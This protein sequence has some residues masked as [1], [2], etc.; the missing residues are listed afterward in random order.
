MKTNAIPDLVESVSFLPLLY[1]HVR[2][3]KKSW[4]LW[5]EVKSLGEMLLSVKATRIQ[6]FSFVKGSAGRRRAAGDI[7]VTTD[8]VRWGR[9]ELDPRIC[10]RVSKEI[11]TLALLSAVK[12]CDVGSITARNAAILVIVHLVW[13]LSSR[14]FRVL[15]ICGAPRRECAHTCVASCHPSSPCPDNRCKVVVRITC[16]CGR[17]SGEVPCDAGGSGGR[18][19]A[20]TEMILSRLPGPLQ[21]LPQGSERVPLGQ[22]KLSCDDECAKHEKRK[23]LADA[24][25]VEI[26]GDGRGGDAN[27]S[28]HLVNDML[29]RDPQ[30]ILAVED[31][32]KSLLLG[33][34]SQNLK[35]HVFCPMPREKREIIHLLAERWCVSVS[36]AGREPRRFAIAHVTN[37]SKVPYTRLLSKS[38]LPSP[39]LFPAPAFNPAVDM[40]PGLVIAFFDVPREVDMSGLVLRFA[41]ECELVWLNDKNALA[42]FGDAARA[43]TALRRVDHTTVY[44]GAISVPGSAVQ[45]KGAWGQSTAAG[46]SFAAKASAKKKAVESSSWVEDAWGQENRN[47]SAEQLT[48]A[49]QRKEP[50]ISIKNPWGAL[51]QTKARVADAQ[52]RGCYVS[53]QPLQASTKEGESSAQGERTRLQPSRGGE[54]Q[55]GSS[56]VSK[57]PTAASETSAN[58]SLVQQNN[59][60][61]DW[62]KLLD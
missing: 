40:E 14:S 2:V 16:G 24:F 50:P 48:G 32:F 42:V 11:P 46:S 29:R 34:K 5:S 58:R 53:S 62:E 33:P 51:E 1:E 12:S 18:H 21:P 55:A 41:G 37:K 4:Q 23:L 49:W 60:E 27:S 20:E 45:S 25:G 13:S 47:T 15:A 43:A 61:D 56:G 36:S 26:S 7:G 22:R 31:R 19:S 57:G 35:V 6:V 3:E 54:E 44:K 30:W 8:A 59:V 9:L 38:P 10:L 28:E 39:G 17:V 52:L